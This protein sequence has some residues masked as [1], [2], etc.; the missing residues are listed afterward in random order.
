MPNF[1][2]DETECE[3]I[4]KF[5]K[6]NSAF[7]KTLFIVRSAASNYP[8]IRWLGF[9]PLVTEW[10]ILDND[11]EMATVDRIF[12]AATKNMDKSLVGILPDGAMCRL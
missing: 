3:R 7:L 8:V 10:S 11:F 12:I 5:M 1:V 4:A 2:K 6:K 9:S